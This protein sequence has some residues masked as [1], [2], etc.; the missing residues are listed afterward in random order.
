MENTRAKEIV[1]NISSFTKDV[2]QKSE[3]L[4]ELFHLQEEIVKATFPEEDCETL[5]LYDVERYF[6]KENESLG[7]IADKELAAFKQSSKIVCNKIKAEISGNKGESKAFRFLECLTGKN[8]ILKNVELQHDDERSEIDAVVFTPKAIFIIEVK[9]TSRDVFIDDEGN[10]YRTGEFLRLDSNILAK[11][12]TKEALL[13]SAIASNDSMHLEIKQIVVFTNNRIQVQNRCKA[14]QTTFLSQLPYLISEYSNSSPERYTDQQL[15]YFF[16]QVK[17]ANHTEAYPITELHI[18]EF[19]NNYAQLLIKLEEG[20]NG[21]DTVTNKEM[22]KNSKLQNT[23]HQILDKINGIL[24]SRE[25]RFITKSVA[26]MAFTT[27]LTYI[28]I[29]HS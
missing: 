11:M 7:N 13:R 25:V 2:Y 27:A 28:K 16:S 3:V 20:Q 9:N 26:S 1:T 19:K 12:N 24:K 14:L 5:K 22:N 10:Y 21:H 15:Y 17:S 6:S 23:A 4:P 18:D 8:L 29:K